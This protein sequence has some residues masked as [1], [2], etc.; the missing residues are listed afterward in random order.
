MVRR[1]DKSPTNVHPKN[2][3]TRRHSKPERRSKPDEYGHAQLRSTRGGCGRTTLATCKGW[4]GREE[5]LTQFE[6]EEVDGQVACRKTRNECRNQIMNGWDWREGTLTRERNESF[7]VGAD[8]VVPRCLQRPALQSTE[9]QGD[10]M[11]C[12]ARQVR[13]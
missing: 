7:F 8:Q 6:P 3:S 5:V 10:L 9:G 12:S 4:R 11:S 1:T 13:Q 2:V